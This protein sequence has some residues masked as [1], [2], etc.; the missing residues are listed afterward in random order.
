MSLPMARWMSLAPAFLALACGGASVPD[1]PQTAPPLTAEEEQLFEDG[2][3]F[4][5]DPETLEGRWRQDWSRE[6]DQRV[7]RSDVVARVTVETLRTDTDLDRR[8]TYRLVVASEE[9]YIGTFPRDL[10]LSSMEGDSGYG[11]LA[12]N[13][14]RILDQDFV[15]FLKWAGAEGEVVPR[16]HHSPASEQ[17]VTRTEWLL[18]RRR[19]DERP[20]QGTTRTIVHEHDD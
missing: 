3:D 8:V 11:T 14:R 19:A 20:Q 12:G 18:D 5:G 2:V 4:V 13:D 6:L 1:R 10:T 17:V 16:W 15:L 7:R 9:T